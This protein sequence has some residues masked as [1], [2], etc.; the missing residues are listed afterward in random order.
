ME[1]ASDFS[2]QPLP[3]LD[4]ATAAA[5]PLGPLAGLTGKWSGQGF[6]VIWRP[7]HPDAPQATG[8]SSSM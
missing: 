3:P 2:F 5:S 6:N 1:L 7:H 4:P 8:A